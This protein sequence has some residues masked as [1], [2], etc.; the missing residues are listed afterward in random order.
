MLWGPR[1]GWRHMHHGSWGE[2]GEGVPPMFND[3]HRRAHEKPSEEKK[4]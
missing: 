3:W 2:N 4:D 1:H